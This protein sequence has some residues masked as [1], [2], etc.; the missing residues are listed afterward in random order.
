MYG[1]TAWYMYIALTCTDKI[2]TN[3]NECD[4]E[5]ST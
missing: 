3:K 1:P 4:P 2:H 5:Y